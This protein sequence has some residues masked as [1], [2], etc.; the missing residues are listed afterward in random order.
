ME[1]AVG[2]SN[3]LKAF[4]S[5]VASA[6]SPPKRKPR[7]RFH[8]QRSL[9]LPPPSPLTHAPLFFVSIHSTSTLPHLCISKSV[10]PSREAWRLVPFSFV[11]DA[12]VSPASMEE[13]LFPGMFSLSSTRLPTIGSSSPGAHVR[14]LF[15]ARCEKKIKQQRVKQIVGQAKSDTILELSPL[16]LPP[17]YHCHT[18]DITLCYH[19]TVSPAHTLDSDLCCGV[20][21][22]PR[23][24]NS[25]PWL[26]CWRLGF[27]VLP[28]QPRGRELYRA[29][30][31]CQGW[32]FFHP[33][34][35]S[36]VFGTAEM[37]VKQQRVSTEYNRH[38]E[39]N[40]HGLYKK[41]RCTAWYTCVCDDIIHGREKERREREKG[42][43]EKEERPGEETNTNQSK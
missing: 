10:L 36:P 25:T 16:P 1:N 11:A 2:E 40:R 18:K 21:Q 8:C 20:S 38:A 29:A 6:G 34:H 5:P 23:T 32:P 27:V 26:S 42:Q 33:Q 41:Q 13:R 12:G 3:G 30:R 31:H 15:S 14:R 24:G 7:R 19:T 9:S 39:Y 17:H 37:M 28:S 4:P 22:Q 43:E 35:L